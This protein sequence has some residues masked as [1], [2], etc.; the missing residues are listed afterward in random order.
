MCVEVR[1]FYTEGS[2]F[3]AI[4]SI[5]PSN[6]YISGSYNLKITKFNISARDVQT[7]SLWYQFPTAYQPIKVIYSLWGDDTP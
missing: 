5:V 2:D 6:E 4:E 3:Y 7:L 1:S